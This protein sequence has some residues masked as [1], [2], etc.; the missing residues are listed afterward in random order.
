MPAPISH[1]VVVQG[2]APALNK[3]QYNCMTC[4]APQAAV[5]PLVRNL[6]P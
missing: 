4:H 5:P 6:S 3:A 1:Y 2:S